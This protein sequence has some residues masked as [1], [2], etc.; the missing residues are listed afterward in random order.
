MKSSK[1][2]R[3]RAIDVQ[4]AIN[5]NKK[6]LNIFKGRPVAYQL[7]QENKKLKEAAKMKRVS[8]I[9]LR[10]ENTKLLS[11]IQ[12]HKSRFQ[13]TISK[14]EKEIEV[15]DL[16]TRNLRYH[17]LQLNLI[18]YSRDAI[19]ERSKI[20]EE[21]YIESKLKVE[22]V[23]S[24]ERSK[25]LKKEA[26]LLRNKNME[27]E[28]T[29][30]PIV[31]EI[32]YKINQQN[33]L[34]SKYKEDFERTSKANELLLK[35]L[36]KQEKVKAFLSKFNQSK[37]KDV[38]KMKMVERQQKS[39]LYTTDEISNNESVQKEYYSRNPRLTPT[40]KLE[41]AFDYK[42]NNDVKRAVDSL[43]DIVTSNRKTKEV[44]DIL[45]KIRQK[46][47]KAVRLKYDID[48]LINQKH[49]ANARKSTA[50]NNCKYF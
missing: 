13:Y 43:K 11:D 46:N 48:K 36:D 45:D 27:I 5:D 24:E 44:S 1:T 34:I 28:S 8:L 40:L 20:R 37:T 14:A 47:A 22:K 16:Q 30:Y 18:Q 4:K 26:K 3:N 23:K 9:I 49:V 21:N 17:L 12:D 32:E 31:E 42:N 6:R 50:N 2:R 25:S 19:L 39:K 7:R 35:I 15:V 33:E 38:F 29:F 41:A 10:N